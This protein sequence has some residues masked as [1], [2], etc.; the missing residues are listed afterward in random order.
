MSNLQK[1]NKVLLGVLLLLIFA[2]MSLLL[3]IKNMKDQVVYDLKSKATKADIVC[4][5]DQFSPE[6]YWDPAEGALISLTEQQEQI[7]WS[8]PQETDLHIVSVRQPH[9]FDSKRPNYGGQTHLNL[10]QAKK[11]YV[12]ALISQTLTEWVLEGDM[13]ALKKI[14][15]VNPAELSVLTNKPESV[16]V[17]YIPKEKLCSYA[18]SASEDQNQ[19]NQFRDMLLSLRRVTGLKETSFLGA[20]TA[21]LLNLTPQKVKRDVAQVAKGLLATTTNLASSAVKWQREKG[22]V[23]AS[24]FQWQG[25]EVS[26]PKKSRAVA[27]VN[28]ELVF[29]LS[30][31]RVMKWQK[32]HED[33]QRLLTPMS[34]PGLENG[35]ALTYDPEQKQLYVF[36]DERGGELFS[37]D[38]ASG[39]WQLVN[40]H[41]NKNISALSYDPLKK[42]LVALGLRGRRLSELIHLDPKGQVES[43]KSFKYPLVVD[44]VRW[45]WSLAKNDRNHWGVILSTVLRPKGV[46]RALE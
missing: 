24:S 33:F 35:T 43:T 3:M 21:E 46:W 9:P 22:Y 18:T 17:V 29:V 42:Q 37:L 26:L 27:V 25:L 13:S 14:V 23:V 16:E 8:S 32:G 15:V 11:P 41:L 2:Q 40:D 1:L 12:L 19:D 39:K 6:A 10:E 34:L 4:G 28:E 20:E 31:G 45:R 5:R 44:R 36:N 30:A 7:W 38:I